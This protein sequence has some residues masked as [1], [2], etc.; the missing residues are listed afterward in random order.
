M[1]RTMR[2]LPFKHFAAMIVCALL[3]LP[4]CAPGEAPPVP[5]P[6]VE[7]MAGNAGHQLGQF[8][9]S[10]VQNTLQSRGF[11]TV[12]GNVNGTGI[13]AIAI[14]RGPD[15]R[16]LEVRFIEVKTGSNAA[17]GSLNSTTQGKQLSDQWIR[18]NLQRA[19][20][21]HPDPNMRR[22]AAEVLEFTKKNPSKV[23]RELHRV[24]VG[25]EKYIVNT[26]DD[27][28]RVVGTASEESLTRLL[29]KLA[30]SDKV[31]EAVRR[32]AQRHL[33]FLKELKAAIAKGLSK[34]GSQS[35][36][37]G[38]RGL[39]RKAGLPVDGV[40]T[41][42][43][44]EIVIETRPPVVK[45]KSIL[46]LAKQPGVLAAGFTFAADQ[47]VATWQ[48]YRGS[49]STA[50]FQRQT[51]QAGIT[52]GVVGVA[53]QLVY[54][55]APTPHGLVLVGVG[56]VAYV[57]TGAAISLWDSLFGHSALSASEL[58]GILPVGFVAAPT[59]ED[60]AAGRA[61]RPRWEP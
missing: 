18:H 50:E 25:A 34:G 15:G 32:W 46:R 29:E 44:E 2:T 31:S 61:R 52:A 7:P 53:T 42:I 17:T 16:I 19:A 54:V 40:L 20:M 43:D 6:K 39:A 8:G 49:I 5:H 13:D 59:I 41:P 3:A 1:N 22:M 57:G 37:E 24:L 33:E 9:E 27:L 11:Q 14:K 36:A 55:L 51:A 45:E 38:A 47:G 4:V 58:E 21:E 26:V 56:I 10:F 23:Y 12:N 28:G 48:Y 35:I 30:H 60:A